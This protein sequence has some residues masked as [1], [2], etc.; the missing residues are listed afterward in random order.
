MRAQKHR[1]GGHHCQRGM[2][3]PGEG[4]CVSSEPD[5]V[6]QGWPGGDV[7]TP[8]VFAF[9]GVLTLRGVKVR[10]CFLAWLRRGLVVFSIFEGAQKGFFTIKPAYGSDCE[11]NQKW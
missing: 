8:Q 5:L 11:N 10:H 6:T 3:A 2:W 1:V 9:S 7:L 4:R